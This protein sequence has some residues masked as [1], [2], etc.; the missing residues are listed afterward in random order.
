MNRGSSYKDKEKWRSTCQKQKRRYYGKTA[1]QYSRRLWT[2]E[3]DK[4]ILKRNLTDVELSQKIHR[5]V[6][7]IQIRRS[8]LKKYRI[9]EL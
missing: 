7:S 2:I 1:F 8:R 3:E 6:A 9:E 4:S 5:S